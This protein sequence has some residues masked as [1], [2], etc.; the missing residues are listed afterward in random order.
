MDQAKVKLP[1][2]DDLDP[3]K[4]E[5]FF[6]VDMDEFTILFYGRDREDYVYPMNNV[7]SFLLD[8]ETD[9]VVGVSYSRFL[10]QVIHEHPFMKEDIPLATIIMGD[11]VGTF[12]DFQPRPTSV[13]GRFLFAVRAGK[14]AWDAEMNRD[15]PLRATIDALPNLA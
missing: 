14:R 5:A 15:E 9:E 3:S 2:Y 1:A 10:R 11:R 7:L 8:I 4:I 12:F 6:D 13:M